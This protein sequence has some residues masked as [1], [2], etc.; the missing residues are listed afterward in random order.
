MADL[1]RESRICCLFFFILKSIKFYSSRQLRY[2]WVP[3]DLL[4]FF[5]FEFILHGISSESHHEQSYSELE[6]HCLPVLCDLWYH[7]LPR[8]RQS[9]QG[10]M[11]SCPVQVQSSFQPGNCPPLYAAR[12]I[13]A[14]CLRD[15]SHHGSA[16]L[17]SAAQS[18][19]RLPLCL[20]S[21][22]LPP[23]SRCLRTPGGAVM[24]SPPMFPFSQ[25][26]Q[27]CAAGCS[28]PESIFCSALYLFMA[29]E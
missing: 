18:L 2:W 7:C 27:S 16:E 11:K 4:L 8:S 25:R 19:L 29:E 22:A 20:G 17:R 9:L 23:G 1:L 10:P 5:Q 28:T 15:S 21:I 13:L 3:S 26:S 14:P 12:S 24:R 6:C